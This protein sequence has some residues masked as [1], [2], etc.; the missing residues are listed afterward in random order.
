[1]D[2][3]KIVPVKVPWQ[4]S[5]SNEIGKCIEDNMC[6]TISLF[7]NQSKKIIQ[8]ELEEL[9]KVYGD[10][11]PDDI[12]NRVGFS[13]INLSFNPMVYF[14]IAFPQTEMFGIDTGKYDTSAIDQYYYGIMD[15]HKIWGQTGI[16]PDPSFYEVIGSNDVLKSDVN[17]LDSEIRHW[18][19]LGHSEEIHILSRSYK[20]TEV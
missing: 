8:T 15:F 2:K 6:L 1:M 19:I 5:P 9:A 7:C 14:G 20:W 3:L 12:Y 11:I 13:E 17:I 18:M 16:C 4:I 10:N